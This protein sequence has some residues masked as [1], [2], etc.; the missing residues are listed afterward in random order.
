MINTCKLGDT[1]QFGGAGIVQWWEH[2]LPTNVGCVKFSNPGYVWVEFVVGSH[3]CSEG[4]SL[5]S[6][7]FLPPQN[8]TLQNFNSIGGFRATMKTTG[9]PVIVLPYKKSFF[10]M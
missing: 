9:K 6:P 3:P 10:L 5:G 7:V 1:C 4:L 2:S 8:P